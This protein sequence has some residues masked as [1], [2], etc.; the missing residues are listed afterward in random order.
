MKRNWVVVGVLFLLIGLVY[1]GHE[2]N[3]LS[4]GYDSDCVQDEIDWLYSPSAVGELLRGFYDETGVQPYIVLKSYDE[5]LKTNDDKQVW[6]DDYFEC[7]EKSNK[8]AVYVYFAEEDTNVHVGEMFFRCSD[9][10]DLNEA[11]FR[12]S[13]HDNWYGDKSTD[14]ILVMAFNALYS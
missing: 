8:I 5:N 7:H 10:L 1:F 4:F 13:L 11:A 6:L 12:E 9:G 3:V 14:E 2:I